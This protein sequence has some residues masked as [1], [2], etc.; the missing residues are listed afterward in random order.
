MKPFHERLARIG[1]EAI[2]RYGFVL[3]GGYA[4]SANGIG[5]RPS[6]DVDLFT[7]D[8]SPEV[9]ARAASDLMSALQATGLTVSVINTGNLFLNIHITDPSS[10]DTSDLQLGFDVRDFPPRQLAVGPVL[11]LRDATANKMGA[12]YGRGEV[13]DFIDV[14]AVV[15]S[16]A[17]TRDEILALGDSKEYLPMDRQILAQ[18]MRSLSGVEPH[19]FEAYLVNEKRRTSIVSR[20]ME[21]ADDIESSLS[22]QPPSPSAS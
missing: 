19:Q 21:W 12:L 6:A 3:A 7:R 22:D 1:L 17:F 15:E 8:M 4:L 20:F 13:R 10:D 16:G 14:D 11:D 18:R 5:D 9:F 2:G